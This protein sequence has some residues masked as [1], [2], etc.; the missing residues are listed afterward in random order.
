[1]QL[2]LRIISVATEDCIKDIKYFDTNEL[3]SEMNKIIIQYTYT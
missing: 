2:V 3:S 1:M